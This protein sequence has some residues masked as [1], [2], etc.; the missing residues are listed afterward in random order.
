LERPLVVVGDVHLAHGGSRETALALGRLIERSK[1]HELV[2]NGDVFNLSLDPTERDPVESVVTMLGPHE[3]LR[4]SLRDKLS[5]GDPVTL[6]PGNHDADVARAGVRDA[7]LAWLELG[8]RAP[9]SIVPWLVRRDGVHVEHGHVYDPDNA[10]THPLVPPAPE[11]EPL[12]VAL[13]RRFL[14][15]NRAFDFA[16]ATEITPLVALTRAFRT[17]GAKTPLLLGRYFTE[18]GE[19]CRSARWRPELLAEKRAGEIRMSDAARAAGMDLAVLRSLDDD[20]PRPTHESFERAFFRLYF[21][22]VVAAVG[23]GGGTVLGVLARSGTL[24]GLGALGALYLVESTRRGTNRYEGLPVKRLRAAAERVR[25]LSNAD[26]VVFGHTHVPESAPGYLNPGSF[27][28]RAGNGR[29]Y[30]FV[31]ESGKGER[32]TI[33]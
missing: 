24:I 22:R 19:F 26:L 13:T 30:A 16:H 2:L 12:G 7:L 4:T 20:R 33:E 14:A 31:D 6:V 3:E 11:T 1:G 10:P 27:T 5:A 9:L 17:F 29:P 25:S 8:A 23:A 15:P 32:R 28:Y 18:A 21:D